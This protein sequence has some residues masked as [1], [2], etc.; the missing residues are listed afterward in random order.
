MYAPELPTITL[1]VFKVKL[2]VLS[3]SVGGIIAQSFPVTL[4]QNLSLS[5]ELPM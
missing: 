2:A 4:S 5:G 1:P 3:L